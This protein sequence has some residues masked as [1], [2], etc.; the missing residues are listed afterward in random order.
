MTFTIS[1]INKGNVT[2]TN[3]TVQ[4]VLPAGLTFVSASPTAT[5][6]AQTLTWNVSSLAPN[7]TT[8]F[9]VVATVATP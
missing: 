2:A 9:T 8:T 1:V 3:F 5:Q 7:Q 6:N 4:D